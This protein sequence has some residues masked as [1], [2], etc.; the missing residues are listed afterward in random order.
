MEKIL[1][2]TT[3]LQTPTVCRHDTDRG[4][5]NTRNTPVEDGQAIDTGL[6]ETEAA[7]GDNTVEGA[8]AQTEPIVSTTER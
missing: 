4:G 3:Y 6:Q 8:T 7:Q 5:A 2:S 1:C